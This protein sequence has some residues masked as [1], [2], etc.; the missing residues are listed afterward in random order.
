MLIWKN[1]PVQIEKYGR[2][3]GS[4]FHYDHGHG[5]TVWAF[6]DKKKVHLVLIDIPETMQKKGIGSKLLQ[7]FIDHCDKM[8]KKACLT[9]QFSDT[10]TTEQLIGFYD[11]F[12]FILNEDGKM[13]R[14]TQKKQV[15]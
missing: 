10:N 2:N 14:E 7:D 11:K 6:E 1:I 13:Y 5:I 9:P 3:E 8:D 12:G 4:D 15:A